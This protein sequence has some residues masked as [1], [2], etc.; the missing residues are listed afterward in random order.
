MWGC[1]GKGAQKW[2][3]MNGTL[4]TSNKCMDVAWDSTANGAA[5]SDRRDTAATPRD[6]YCSRAARDL[7]NPQANRCFNLKTGTAA[8][9]P[10][11][12]TARAP[13]TD[14]PGRERTARAPRTGSGDGPDFE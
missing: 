8:T 6:S 11:S 5:V 14:R 2:P 13:R 7:V 12:G 4:Q 9:A 3:F 1:N 10:G